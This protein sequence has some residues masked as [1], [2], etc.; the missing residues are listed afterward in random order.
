MKCIKCNKE[1]KGRADAKFCSA[2]CRVMAAREKED[3]K[4]MSAE[5]KLPKTMSAQE[6][7]DGI[8]SYPKDKWVDSPEH[9][10]LLRRLEVLSLE[11][12]RAGGYSI[13]SRRLNEVAIAKAAKAR[14]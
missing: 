11:E 3:V 9:L 13:P 14:A 1:F 10:E 4:T 6:L 8:D 2:N 12:L 5:V 7:Y